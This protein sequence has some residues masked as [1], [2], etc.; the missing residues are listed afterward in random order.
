V[1]IKSFCKVKSENVCKFFVTFLFET[2]SPNINFDQ[3]SLL[4]KFSHFLWWQPF[5]D[6]HCSP[7][8]YFFFALHT[9]RNVHEA[10]PL[11]GS[12]YWPRAA[13]SK[14]PHFPLSSPPEILISGGR[15]FNCKGSLEKMPPPP[16]HDSLKVHFLQEVCGLVALSLVSAS[17]QPPICS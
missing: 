5:N 12:Y 17:G 6:L 7:F 9:L 13:I 2:C 1:K 3:I 10:V 16:L 11:G 15:H 4:P 8:S 14:C